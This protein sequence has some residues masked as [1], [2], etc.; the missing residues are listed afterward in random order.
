MKFQIGDDE[1]EALQDE[2]HAVFKLYFVLRRFMD[3]ATGLVGVKRGISWKMVG[4]YLYV[5][6][7]SGRHASETGEP[8]QKALRKM[9]ERLQTLGLV[10][11]RSEGMRLI[12]FLPKADRG[13]SLQKRRG[14]GGAEEGQ[15]MRVMAYPAEIKVS[16]V[17]EGQRR[18]R[19]IPSEEGHT[20]G[21][22]YPVEEKINI[23]HP[24][25]QI[26]R[27]EDPDTQGYPEKFLAFWREYP[28]KKSKGQ[29]LRAWLKLNAADQQA[30]SSGLPG[31]KQ[32]RDWRKENGRYIPH[33]ATWLNARGWEDEHDG[34][35]QRRGPRSAED[36]LGATPPC[37]GAVIDGEFTVEKKRAT[38]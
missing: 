33:P 1:W 5:A 8:T 36:W 38:A 22:R 12:F 29:A 16:D 23:Q 4:E 9:A 10:E 13:E 11:S 7:V 3:F 32:S 18:G 20:S 37:S 35:P 19:P 17:E 25:A 21:I 28:R 31:A 2:P 34:S 27:D 15:T 24:L 6:P 26:D 30:A 14:R